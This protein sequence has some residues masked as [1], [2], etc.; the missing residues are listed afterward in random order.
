MAVA[1]GGPANDWSNVAERAER[2][3]VVSASSG[4]FDCATASLRM[5]GVGGG[6]TENGPGF[7]AMDSVS[8]TDQNTMLPQ[9]C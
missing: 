9:Q 3:G 2:F 8:L 1:K 7:C 5:T 4:S 6:V